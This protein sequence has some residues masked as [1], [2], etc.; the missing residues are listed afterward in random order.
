M[1]SASSSA[2][3]PSPEA[4]SANGAQLKEEKGSHENDSA[5]APVP[6]MPASISGLTKVGG[7]QFMF[8]ICSRTMLSLHHV[9]CLW[10]R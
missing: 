7:A 4:L 5:G 6:S 9:A 8:T 2:D 10:F 3:E 1:H